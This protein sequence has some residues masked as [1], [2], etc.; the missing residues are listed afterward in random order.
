MVMH[1]GPLPGVRPDF[2]GGAHAGH[3]SHLSNKLKA[4][5]EPALAAVPATTSKTL[6]EQIAIHQGGGNPRKFSANPSARCPS[7]CNS[8]KT[9][10]AKLGVR[11][12]RQVVLGTHIA[13]FFAR[14]VGVVRCALGLTPVRWAA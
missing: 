14:A 13:D 3:S 11:F 6:E 10:A 1:G 4:R 12:R 7:S 9:S 2:A 5:Q 8:R